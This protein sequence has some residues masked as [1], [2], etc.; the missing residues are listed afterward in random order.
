MRNGRRYEE[1]EREK[2]SMKRTRLWERTKTAT[3]SRVVVNEP[4]WRSR[5]L[6][7]FTSWRN[8]LEGS[9]SINTVSTMRLILSLIGHPAFSPFLYCAI[10]LREIWRKRWLV[11]HRSS[12]GWV[13]RDRSLLC[14]T[15]GFSIIKYNGMRSR[16]LRKNVQQRGE[17]LKNW[18]HHDSFIWKIRTSFEK[19]EVGI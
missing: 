7:S 9:L 1:R 6:S 3:G 5:S 16:F 2:E 14:M 19:R 15:K 10:P 12:F 8:C 11:H 4:S 18:I 13:T 17:S